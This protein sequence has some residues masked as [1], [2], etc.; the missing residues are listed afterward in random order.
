MSHMA[1]EPPLTYENRKYMSKRCVGFRHFGEVNYSYPRRVVHCA[2]VLKHV[3]IFGFAS[4]FRANRSSQKEGHT[5]EI[6]C[7]K[8]QLLPSWLFV[9]YQQKKC[10]YDRK[11][12][13]TGT[14]ICSPGLNIQLWC[15]FEKGRLWILQNPRRKIVTSWNVWN[16]YWIT[17]RISVRYIWEITES[18]LY[19]G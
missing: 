14:E 1:Y 4:F 8:F 19:E 15:P 2:S 10:C 11:K 7:S 6:Y 18:V 5:F 9:V 17:T 13:R 3:P 12:S 16:F